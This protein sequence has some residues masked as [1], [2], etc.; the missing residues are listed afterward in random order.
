M[1]R[2]MHVVLRTQLFDGI[3]PNVPV[4]SIFKHSLLA[5]K[6]ELGRESYSAAKSRAIKIRKSCL[7]ACLETVSCL[8]I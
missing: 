1:Q 4:P 3:A 2:P 6:C 7:D 8:K 5:D